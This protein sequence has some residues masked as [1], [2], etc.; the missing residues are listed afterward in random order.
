MSRHVRN[1]DQPWY[2]QEQV[3]HPSSINGPVLSLNPGLIILSCT[4]QEGIDLEA[5]RL[6][7]YRQKN[8]FITQTGP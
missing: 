8:N 1:L 4:G 2:S 3:S 7:K 6:V 5:L